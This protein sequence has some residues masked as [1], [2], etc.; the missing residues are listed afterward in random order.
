MVHA[1]SI[2]RHEEARVLM[3]YTMDFYDGNLNGVITKET[4]LWL[5]Q[6][7]S[8]VGLYVEEK[9]HCPMLKQTMFD[10]CVKFIF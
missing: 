5:Y 6:S 3:E 4:L 1:I 7:V 9:S 8:R 2:S 10:G